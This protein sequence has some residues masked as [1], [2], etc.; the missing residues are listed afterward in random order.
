V[1]EEWFSPS[2]CYRSPAEAWTSPC[3]AL[4]RA[5]PA[6]VAAAI[7]ERFARDQ[8]IDWKTE[9]LRRQSS[10]AA[11]EARVKE[12]EEVHAAA[13]ASLE[14]AEH[15]LLAWQEA[16]AAAHASAEEEGLALPDEVGCAPAA[17][18]QQSVPCAYST[19]HAASREDTM[20]P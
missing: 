18:G 10:L 13:L 3:T 9:L 14:E 15:K 11:V 8:R 20:P 7:A 1:A 6:Q 19:H 17:C 4:H 12:A 16:Q 5:T 2:G